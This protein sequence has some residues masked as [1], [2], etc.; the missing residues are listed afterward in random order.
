M[1]LKEPEPK[2]YTREKKKT[3]NESCLDLSFVDG[4]SAM[5]SSW[6]VGDDN[7]GSDHFPITIKLGAAPTLIKETGAKT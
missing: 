5:V 1:A 2:K 4:K 6:Q 3:S 7:W